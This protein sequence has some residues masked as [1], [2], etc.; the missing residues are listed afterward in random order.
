MGEV[1]RFQPREGV[2]IAPASDEGTARRTGNAE[3]L[4]FLGVR[5]ERHEET[6]AGRVKAPAKRGR[7]RKRA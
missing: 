1:I 2:R 5:Y 7:P 4:L 6:G 3:I